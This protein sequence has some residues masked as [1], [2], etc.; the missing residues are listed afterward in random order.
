[1]EG[2]DTSNNPA[3]TLSRAFLSRYKY[4]LFASL[5]FI[6]LIG[7]IVFGM[8][9][10]GKSRDTDAIIVKSNSDQNVMI[11]IGGAI[12]HSG[13][14]ELSLGSR[15]QDAIE[16]AGGFS[17]DVDKDW[18]STILNRAE[19]L[20]DGQKIVIPLLREEKQIDKSSGIDLKININKATQSELTTLPGIGNAYA[21]RIIEHR[22][23]SSVD[24]LLLVPGIGPSLLSSI[25]DLVG[26]Y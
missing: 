22:P 7:G 13:V 3:D 24:D 6:S 12:L 4:E 21:L 5:A 14:Y 26:V 18:V 16:Y 9:V 1:V 8:Q 20:V 15:I 11:D 17:G 10:L 19:V 25:R 2:F 23:Y